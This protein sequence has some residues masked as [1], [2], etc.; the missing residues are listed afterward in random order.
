M[1][2]GERNKRTFYYALYN[3]QT[4]VEDEWGN[5]TA[6]YDVSY[7]EPVEMRGN[8]SPSKGKASTEMFGEDLN[9]NKTILIDDMEC[10][11]DEHSVLWIDN[12]PDKPFDYIVVGV[13]KSLNT[14]AYAIKKVDVS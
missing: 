14:I 13:A 4:E 1:G 7:T 10:P 8:I 5:A 2:L 9:Y 11:I 3:G 6:T 12:T